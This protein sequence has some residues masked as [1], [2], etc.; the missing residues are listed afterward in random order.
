MREFHMAFPMS[1]DD[2]VFWELTTEYAVWVL[3]PF[4]WC[5]KRCLI[6]VRGAGNGHCHNCLNI[7]PI[8][9]ALKHA[10]FIFKETGGRKAISTAYKIDKVRENTHEL[11]KKGGGARETN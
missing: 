4:L 2:E 3:F 1:K 10:L 11:K 5:N 9:D 7:V 8:Y 6:S